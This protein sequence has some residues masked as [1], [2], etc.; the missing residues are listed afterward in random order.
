MFPFN[1]FCKSYTEKRFTPYVGRS[2]L[3]SQRL[4][5]EA[6]KEPKF[7]LGLLTHHIFGPF[8]LKNQVDSHRLDSLDRL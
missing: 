8:R 4:Q 5:P 6:S 1:G 7:E 3:V 2:F